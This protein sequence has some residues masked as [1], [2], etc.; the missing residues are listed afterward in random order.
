[1]HHGVPGTDVHV[2]MVCLGQLCMGTLHSPV[3]MCAVPCCA[4]EQ[5]CTGHGVSLVD[6]QGAWSDLGPPALAPAWLLP[7]PMG[8]LHGASLCPGGAMSSWCHALCCF[9]QGCYAMCGS[10]MSAKVLS[11]WV[12]SLFRNSSPGPADATEDCVSCDVPAAPLGDAM[13]GQ[14]A[15]Q[16]GGSWGCGA[17]GR[18]WALHFRPPGG[19][20]ALGTGRWGQPWGRQC[21]SLCPKAA[22]RVDWVAPG[23]N[24]ELGDLLFPSR[25]VELSTWGPMCHTAGRPLLLRVPRGSGR[26]VT[27]LT[28]HC[29]CPQLAGSTGS[30][31]SSPH[32]DPHFPEPSTHKISPP[33]V[34]GG[35]ACP[36][37]HRAGICPPPPPRPP[38]G[39]P[40]APSCS[41]W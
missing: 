32:G 30:R 29:Q 20:G 41:H 25:A 17:G 14:P 1:M 34:A 4:P 28:C 21:V 12:L 36:H 26:E 24:I 18:A 39:T 35:K 31:L 22:F 15:S 19:W 11:L 6:V 10:R 27:L 13:W 2:A 7:C 3:R 23:G 33:V 9:A 40:V 8:A 5:T 16:G 38:C 37:T